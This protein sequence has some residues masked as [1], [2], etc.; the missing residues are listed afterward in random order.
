M[1]QSKLNIS[2]SDDVGWIGSHFFLNTPGY[3]D[4]DHAQIPR[5][6]WPYDHHR[7][8]GLYNPGEGGYP[9]CTQWWTDKGIGIRDRAL[10]LVRPTIWQMVTRL[11]QSKGVY[12]E[13]ILRTIVS[14]RNMQVSQNGRVYPGYGGDLDG[15]LFNA[16]ARTTSTLGHLVGSLGAFPAFDSVRQALPMVQA[17]LLMALVVCFPIVILFSAY[18]IKTIITLSF[19]QFA[20]CFLTFWWELAR[21]LDSWLIGVL[22]NSSSHSRWN[23]AG[24]QNTQDDL[25]INL[26]MGTMFIVLPA[27]WLGS[28][29]WAG[30]AIGSLLSSYNE[31][32]TST[33]QKTGGLGAGAATKIASK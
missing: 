30:V 13:A 14:Q 9:T 32:G 10:S 22:Y 4:T 29:V 20:L 3:Y 33:A 31:K 1:Q 11:G 27:F 16:V 17:L 6:S 26:V 7:D 18:S 15:T 23:F 5:K 2:K 28:L 8:T 19:V 21:W 12:E 25:I 24:L